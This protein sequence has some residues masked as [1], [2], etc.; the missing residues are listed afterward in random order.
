[1]VSLVWLNVLS[2]VA[3]PIYIKLLGSRS[4]GIVAACSSLQLLFTFIDLGFSQIVPRWIAR[5]ADSPELLRQYIRVFQKIYGVLAVAGFAL[6]QLAAYPLAHYWFNVPSDQVSELVS[7]I[8]IIALQLLF[9]FANN[10]Y[11][12]VWHGLQL[13]V[14]A[15]V[16]TC[17]FGTLKHGLAIATLAWLAASPVLYATAF[18]V[19]ALVEFGVSLLVTQRRGLLARSQGESVEVRG[20]IREAAILSVGILVGLAVSQMD[21]VVLSRIVPVESFGVYVVVLNLA[22]A[23]LALQTPLTRA[24]FPILVQNVK[25]H[26]RADPA[27]L[28]RLLTGNTL[29]CIA[30]AL[31]VCAFADS[32]LRL[33][34]HNPRFVEQGTLPLRLLLIAMCFNVLYNCFYQVIIAQGRAHVVV[35]LNLVCLAVGLATA[36][37]FARHG[38]LMVGGL[39]WIATTLTQLILGVTWYWQNIHQRSVTLAS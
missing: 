9:Q 20:F 12:G 6:I 26:G 31:V 33:W 38:T 25:E 29:L 27:T 30:P 22:M 3:I 11:I 13:Q 23:F 21:R 34:V 17:V 35:K 8:R 14:Q 1:M 4:W 36:A 37:T 10:L 19:V 18:S 5:E 7:C 28:R 15:N 32:V 39:I 24:Y 2:V 16:R